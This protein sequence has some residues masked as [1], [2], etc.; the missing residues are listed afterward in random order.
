MIFYNTNLINHQ[1][2]LSIKKLLTQI[3]ALF[4]QLG[5]I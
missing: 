2:Y 4:E 3:I 1:H 5:R